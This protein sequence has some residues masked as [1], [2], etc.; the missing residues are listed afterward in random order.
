MGI[1]LAVILVVYVLVYA[2]S[3]RE[4]KRYRPGRDYQFAPAWYLSRPESEGPRAIESGASEE[5]GE[6]GGASDRW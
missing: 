3:P 2:S 4:S 1:P 5:P 6:T